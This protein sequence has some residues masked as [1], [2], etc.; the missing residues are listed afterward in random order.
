MVITKSFGNIGDREILLFEILQPDGSHVDLIN[1]GACIQSIVLRTGK[2]NVDVVLGYDDPESYYKCTTYFGQAVGRYANRIK[3]GTFI[4]DGTEYRL[5]KNDGNN[6][7]HG[8]RNGLSSRIWNHSVQDESVTFTY[9]SPDGEEG[10]PGNMEV[11]VTYT[12][13]EGILSVDYYAK[14]DKACPVNLTN[15]SY[16]DLSGEGTCSQKDEI[17][18]VFSDSYLASDEELIPLAIESLDKKPEFDFRKERALGAG[19]TIPSIDNSFIV[20]GSGF[21]KALDMRSEETDIEMEVWTDLPAVHI[22]NAFNLG[23]C[24]GKGGKEYH[25]FSGIAFETGSLPDSPN[26]PDFPDT[27]LRPGHDFRSTTEFRFFYN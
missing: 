17:L 27:V 24:T 19:G 10:Y 11:S 4:L 12:F 7:L 8:G 16:F 13:S 14:T 22:Y 15:H 25:S 6:S 23:S 1:L 2:G 5:D 3:N 18:E 20:R 21:R 9:N 26:R